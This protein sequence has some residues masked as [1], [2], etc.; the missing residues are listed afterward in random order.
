MTDELYNY[1]FREFIALPNEDREM[2]KAYGLHAKA[3]NLTEKDVMEWQ[4]GKVKQ[5]QDVINQPSLSWDDLTEIVMIALDR[6]RIDVEE[7]RWHEVLKFYN[8]VVA[9]IKQVNEKE[10]QLSYE[11]DAK[12][13]N[14]GI[15]QYAQFGWFGTLYRLSGG[16]PLKYEAIGQQPYSVIFATLLL[17]KTDIEYNKALMRQNRI[18]DV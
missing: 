16:D 11:P 2:Y 15:D 14:A 3:K 12:E 17:Q 8:Y 6:T 5:I 4:W 10:Q 9:A 1:S 13:L 7:M 18:S